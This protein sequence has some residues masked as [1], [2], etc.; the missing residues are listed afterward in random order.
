MAKGDDIE[1]RLIKF[2]VRIIRL[3]ESMPKTVSGRHLSGQLVRSGT[4][5]AFNYGEAGGGKRSDF[6]HK[7]RVVQKELNESDI[8]LKIICRSQLLPKHQLADI[9]DECDQLCRIVNASIQ[10]ALRNKR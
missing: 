2:A 4:S 9:M 3:C 10:T 8:N 7:M 1:E 5:P 6:V